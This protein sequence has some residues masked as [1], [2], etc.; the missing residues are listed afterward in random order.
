MSRLIV[1]LCL[2]VVGGAPLWGQEELA[3][4]GNRL[5]QESDFEGALAA[6]LR[7][8]DSGFEA[9]D[10]NYNIGNAYFKTGDVARSILFYERAAKLMPGDSL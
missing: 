3:I 4:E 8:Y 7:V 1:A 6:Y 9:G 2:M 10:L 5:Y